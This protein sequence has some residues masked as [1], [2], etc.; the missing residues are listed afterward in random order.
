MNTWIKGDTMTHLRVQ[1]LAERKGLT[2][3]ALAKAADLQWPTVASYWRNEKTQYD[4]RALDK[5]A[6][7]L[8]VTVSELFAG[9]PDTTPE[10]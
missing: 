4:K 7:A 5:I 10:K 6:A 1:E 3:Y 8:G 9:E 2:I